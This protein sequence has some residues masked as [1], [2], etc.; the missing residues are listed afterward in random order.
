[1][2]AFKPC[3]RPT[4]P[5]AV[6]LLVA[7]LAPPVLAADGD[8][9]AIPDD[10]EART[11]RS[12]TY[13]TFPSDAPTAFYARSE[14]EGAPVDDAFEVDW[15]AGR[16]MVTYFPDT[17]GAKAL[18]LEVRLLRLVEFIDADANGEVALSERLQW[19]DL[20]KSG[21]G[22]A[23]IAEGVQV[24]GAR[25]ASFTTHR[26]VLSVRL[27]VAT[28]FAA[29]DG[30]RA[31][32]P[33]EVEVVFQIEGWDYEALESRLALEVS[34]EGAAQVQEFTP[35][36]GYALGVGEQALSISSASAEASLAWERTADVDGARPA[37]IA[38][39][40][41]PGTLPARL[42][43]WYPRGASIEQ[44]LRVG[45]LSS[46][47]SAQAAAPSPEVSAGVYA[48]TAAAVASL[49]GATFYLR[50]KRAR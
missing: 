48:A 24:D 21:Y 43:F 35:P 6:L 1:M 32:A 23:A 15:S 25:V 33:V 4:S 12:L 18:A 29:V 45:V 26:E 44:S 30:E 11:E 3:M 19:L 13:R 9:D 20:D 14:S 10:L 27:A 39:T 8:A 5:L 31:L 50:R 40:P 46:V 17:A 16:L 49:V 34:L 37:V 42:S 7:L 22:G 2:R 38:S 36:S 41:S 28:R 47:F